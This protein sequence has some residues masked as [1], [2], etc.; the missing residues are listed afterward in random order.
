MEELKPQEEKKTVKTEKPKRKWIGKALVVV[1]ILLLL[2][3]IG[4]LA[5]QLKL[6]QDQAT[7]TTTDK[8]KLQTQVDTLNKQLASVTDCPAA[9]TSSSSSTTGSC[10]PQV[11]VAQTIKDNISAAIS[12]KNYAALKGYMA[13]TVTVVY[14]ATEKGGSE[15]SDAAV[16][17]LGY[18]SNATT[19]WNFSLS[20]AALNSFKAGFYTQYFN[21]RTYVGQAA[22]GYVVS[23]GFDDCA[24][25]N[26]IFIS[27]NADLLL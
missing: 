17:D 27:V 14:A 5:W 11:E 12:S 6:S 9:T 7:K 23:F 13:S 2:G 22:N 8:Q 3:A 21:G 15:S 26:R 1:L 20:T 10:S 19:P 24:K 18:L 16:T 4:W 25:I